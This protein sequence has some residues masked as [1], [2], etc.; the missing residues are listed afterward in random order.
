MQLSAI[1]WSAS[2]STAACRSFFPFPSP[3][4]SF[5]FPLYIFCPALS[6]PALSCPALSCPV[7]PFPGFMQVLSELEEVLEFKQAEI[8][9]LA[10][11]EA[12]AAVSVLYT[13]YDADGAGQVYSTVQCM[14]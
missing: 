3:S 7:L 6:F 10:A 8:R 13:D 5:T 2:R 11:A 9:A 4:F 14:C 12:R 1:L